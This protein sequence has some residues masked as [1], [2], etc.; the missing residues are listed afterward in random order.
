MKSAVL[1]MAPCLP[2]QVRRVIVPDENAWTRRDDSSVARGS[3]GGKS[4]LVGP[5][6][7]AGQAKRWADSASLIPGLEAVSLCAT[8][9]LSALSFPADITTSLNATRHSPTW[10]RRQSRELLSNF[11]HV[12]IESATPIMGVRFGRD[13]T[14]EVDALRDAGVK[15]GLIWHGSDI[16][17]PSHHSRAHSGSPFRSDLGGLTSNLQRIAEANAAVAD[18]LQLSEF[19]STPDLLEYRT[20]A[21]WLPTLHDSALWGFGVDLSSEAR[22]HPNRAAGA[23]K[24]KVVHIPSR[25]ALKGTSHIREAVA[26]I[27]DLVEYVE[28]QGL[29]PTEVVEHVAGAD[30]VIDQVGMGLFGV[31]SLEAMSLGKVVVAEV[32]TFTRERIL[33]LTGAEVPIVEATS[34]TIA[35]T[36]RMLAGDDGLRQEIGERGRKYVSEV[37]TPQR[38]G[39]TLDEDFLSQ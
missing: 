25:A 24:L 31:A 39:R 33:E 11:S 1:S 5:L 18:Q 20:N 8:R 26:T 32:G 29:T 13:L 3:R 38:V 23:S 21:T 36:V 7:T 34:S 35:E 2:P 9:D 27:S 37:H 22:R 4:L 17:L 30:V 14:R 6:N 15:V 16:R 10:S 28:L 19:V 12:L